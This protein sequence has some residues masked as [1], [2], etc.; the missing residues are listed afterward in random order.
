MMAAGAESG[1]FREW[2]WRMLHTPQLTATCRGGEAPRIDG[3][4]LSNL[5]A[6]RSGL[7]TDLPE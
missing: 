4:A 3:V 7:R 6:G 1:V 5:G 2:R